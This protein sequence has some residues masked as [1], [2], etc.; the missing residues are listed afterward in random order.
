MDLQASENVLF[1]PAGANK[2]IIKAKFIPNAFF[3]EFFEGRNENDRNYILWI[4]VADHDL[5][6]NFSDRVSLLIDYNQMIKVIPPAGAYPGMTN[7]FIEHPQ[8]E[9][10]AGALKYFGFVEDD[11][12]SR[13]QFSVDKTKD[14]LLRN[15][16]FGYEVVNQDTEAAYILEEYPVNLNSFPKDTNNVQQIN[17]DDIRGF[18]LEDGNNKNWVKIL[19]DE[20]ADA[21][22]IVAYKAFFATKIRWEDWLQR[23]NVPDEY[24]NN[25]LLND[26]QHN[27]WLDYL[28]AG[29][30]GGHKI[31]FF[32]FT[33]VIE[34]GEFKRYKNTFE[35]TFNDYDENL[36]I[37]TEHNYYRHSDDTLLNV[38]F[39]PETGKP[40][41]V[42]LNNEPTRIEIIYTHL[43]EDFNFDK[44]YAVTTLE[45]D[46]GAGE[47][48]HRQLSSKW[49]SESDNP[50]IPL[51]NETNLKFELIAPRQIK[52]TC[53][54]DPN[55]LENAL[56]YKISGRI[57]CWAE[58][59]GSDDGKYEK[60]YES[61]YE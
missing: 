31:N 41:G 23:D 48:E 57:G 40:L 35:I 22:N 5:Q 12:L 49:G 2:A 6:V 58:S 47:F 45:I 32:V 1:S 36:D 9:I 26:G 14:I 61:K 52:T 16:V 13:L 28:R 44:M 10:V 33:E 46:K 34:N 55:K 29:V 25:S 54:V 18:K 37:E 7:K 17:F 15:M 59:P 4:S 19:R 20:V 50:L 56:R 27:D 60:K 3:T 38:G 39:D 24:Y 8:N 30:V 21:N 51:E 11:V 42:L 53:L 43:S